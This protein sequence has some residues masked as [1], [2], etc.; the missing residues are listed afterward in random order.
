MNLLRRSIEF[1][2]INVI[3][4]FKIINGFVYDNFLDVFEFFVLF[5]VYDNS[6]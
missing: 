1:F 2:K 4:L 5:F 6:Y 3:F